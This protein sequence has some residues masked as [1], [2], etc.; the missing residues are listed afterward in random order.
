MTFGLPEKKED[1][2][3]QY[4][5]LVCRLREGGNE[6]VGVLKDVSNTTYTLLPYLKDALNKPGRVLE[7]NTPLFLEK[8]NTSSPVPYPEHNIEE[9]ADCEFAKLMG[10]P[11]KLDYGSRTHYGVLIG[12]ESGNYVLTNFVESDEVRNRYRISKGKTFIP[13][14]GA[15]VSR[16]TT[17]YIKKVVNDRNN[18]IKENQKRQQGQQQDP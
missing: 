6:H 12:M 8:Q 2:Y 7:K 18:N 5:G 10:K 16:T 1:R 15:T 17:A 11:V 9:L 13:I 4:V 3:K 14:G